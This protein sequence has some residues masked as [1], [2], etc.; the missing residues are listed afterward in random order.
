[1]N[2]TSSIR[3]RRATRDDLGWVLDVQHDAFGRVA[4]LYGIDPAILP[5]MQETVADLEALLDAGTTFFVACA[6]PEVVVGSV[7]SHIRDGVAH[8][9]RLVVR[10]GWLRQGIATALMDL[11]ERSS[12]DA[13]VFELFT[14]ADATAP[15][16]LYTGRGYRVVRTDTSGP[17]PLVWLEKRASD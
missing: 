8:V 11:L 6:E 16:A 1:V 17:V 14:G 9:G 10:E 3:V 2:D 5:P 13:T 7:R 15:L 12:T 4:R